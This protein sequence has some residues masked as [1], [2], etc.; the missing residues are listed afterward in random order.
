MLQKFSLLVL[1]CTAAWA[2]ITN[3]S[4]T[5]QANSAI[6]LDSGSTVSSGGDLR[7]TGSTLAP[8]GTAK[9]YLI[10][11]LGDSGIALI[12]QGS[13]QSFQLIETSTPIPSSSL[14]VG[15]AIA[16]TTNGGNVAKVLVTA[17]GGSIS[18]KFTTYGNTTSAGGTNAPTITAILNNSSRIGAS[19]PNYGI[20]PSSLFVIQGTGL[21][22]PGVPVL[23]DTT[24]G[25]QTTLN[26]ASINV[27]VNGTTVRPAIYYTSPAQIA[28]VL[29]AATPAGTGTIT[30]SYKGV[31]SAPF[32]MKVIPSALGFTTFN[33]AALAT[34]AVTGSLLSYTQS[35]KPGEIVIF[36]GTGLGADPLDSDTTY[37]STPNQIKANLQLF[38][39]SSRAQIVYQGASVYPGVDV[40]GATI[41]DDVQMGCFVSVGAIIDG[42]S[43]N[44]T[45]LPI[46]A[47]GGVCKDPLT[48][49]DGSQ[50]TQAGGQA[51]YKTASLNVFQSN[52]VS[53][54]G[55]SVTASAASASFVQVSGS[56]NATAPS[57]GG[58]LLTQTTS[59]PTI[60]GLNAG[61]ITMTPPNGTPVTLQ[62]VASGQ[63]SSTLSST[64][65]GGTYRFQG[66]GG[67]Q[68]GAFD[69]SVTMPSPAINWTNQS[70]AATIT[71]SAGL[72]VTW[73]GGMPGTYVSIVG[74]SASNG[75]TGGFNCLAKVEA[76]Q[77]TVPSY[78][79]LSLPAGQ[80]N[81][82]VINNS[83]Y[84]TFSISGVDNTSTFA[85]INFTQGST[86]N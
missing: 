84:G 14:P 34:D 71:R 23:Q 78:I 9:T 16:V 36:W 43:S 1:V 77:F 17:I 10:G 54:K 19:F 7:W 37:T 70:A 26:G 5:L 15:E 41:P 24:K 47:D 61:S 65:P 40:I 20:A 25:L 22:D 57:P 83:P 50:I 81:V 52:S 6:N 29:P 59:T 67:T 31:S 63:F 30:V 48:G 11:N 66:S 85:T 76:G 27:T 86:Y 42:I 4:V 32:T 55:T 39:G 3:Q 13:L 49:Q 60:T 38:I 18:L 68:V 74:G 64:V 53:A 2:D 33:G 35:G 51:T 21:A 80:G 62:S 73:T 46:S 8:Q 75:V 12:N 58:C 44:I 69:A 45:S 28:A 79:L 72:L 56:F 82:A